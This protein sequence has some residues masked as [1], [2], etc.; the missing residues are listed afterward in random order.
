[1]STGTLII[2]NQYVQAICQGTF[3]QAGQIIQ[4]ALRDGVPPSVLYDQVFAPSLRY[5]GEMWES[6]KMSVA[7]EHL[8]TG[9]TEYCRTLVAGQIQ[10]QNSGNVGRVLLSNVSGNQHTL[11]INLLCDVFRWR[12]WEVFPLITAIPEEQLAQAANLYRVDVVCLSVALPAQITR[13]VTTIKALRQSQ[14]LGIIEVGGPAFV[15]NYEAVEL[16]GADFLGLDAYSTVLE[17]EKRLEKAKRK[18]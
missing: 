15:N 16:T 6:G 3:A 1:M 17:A 8:A 11:G 9:I 13:T 2:Y 5:V 14:W 4:D 7:Q 18:N 12:G 10:I